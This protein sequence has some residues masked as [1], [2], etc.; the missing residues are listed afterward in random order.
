[1]TPD[2]PQADGDLARL[3]ST[4]ATGLETR[5]YAARTKMKREAARVG[6]VEKQAL[7]LEN[8]IQVTS[9]EKRDER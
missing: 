4:V 8:G 9:M 7:N 1:M 5:M 6:G 2:Q 3:V